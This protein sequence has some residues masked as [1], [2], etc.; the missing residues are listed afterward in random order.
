MASSEKR[1]E[2]RWAKEA[3]GSFEFFKKIVNA[4][5]DAGGYDI[6]A[7]RVLT[8]K[9]LVKD[10]AQ[11]IM[12]G[13]TGDERMVVSLNTNQDW[14]EMAKSMG[15]KQVDPRLEWKSTEREGHSSSR[16]VEMWMQYWDE[17]R[18]IET[19]K[20]MIYAYGF[21][22]STLEEGLALVGER[23]D[24]A[25]YGGLLICHGTSTLNKGGHLVVPAIAY[26]SAKGQ[27]VIKPE[28]LDRRTLADQ[29]RVFPAFTRFL[30]SNTRDMWVV[31]R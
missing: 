19:W 4:V 23:P 27:V 18:R 22:G 7:R 6:D 10:I 20:D 24:L 8:D 9:D 5:H 13:Y 30:T 28:R 25:R 26:D 17:P 11:R 16:K 14:R 2:S 21:E 31:N 3:G 1:P 12:A 29:A 15:I